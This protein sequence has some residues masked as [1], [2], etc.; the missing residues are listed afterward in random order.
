MS[1]IPFYGMGNPIP[2]FVHNNVLIKIG[3]IC[4]EILFHPGEVKA[5]NV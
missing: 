1:P 4:L 3:T 5:G 2:N